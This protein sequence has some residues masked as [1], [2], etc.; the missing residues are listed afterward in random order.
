MI[1][2]Q[3]IIEQL[4]D[5]RVMALLDKLGIP[6]ED[7]PDCLIMPTVCHNQNMEEAS[8]KLYYYKNTHIFY[9][10]TEDGAMSIFNFLKHFYEVR[11][12]AYD[13]YTD[14]YELVLGCSY[15]GEQEYNPNAYKS[16]RDNY[17]LRKERKE[18]PSYPKEVMESF[19]KYYPIEWLNDGISKEAM[20]KFG[21][22]FSPSQNKIIIPHYDVGGRLVGIR[23]RALNEE[24]IENWG[25]YMPVQ[26]EGKWYSHPLSLN[27][28]GLNQTKE[29]IKATGIA[30]LFEAEK[31]V[32]QMESFNIPNCAVAVCGNKLNKYALDILVR[33]C[34][35]KEIVIC[36]DK[37]ELPHES[38]YFN[39]LYELC[40]KY[41]VYS[42]F[43]FIY[44][45]ENLLDLKDSPTDK[46]EEIFL[47]LLKK[48][49]KV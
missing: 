7:K 47:K 22:R 39:H 18:L 29:N 42:N 33:A 43:S 35:P 40:K 24:D 20:D 13:W 41:S 45:R 38:K 15:F 30:Y 48:R 6:Y 49:V 8:Q 10:Y 25:K 2:Y 5:N 16:I 1:D 23:G 17:T 26:I 28:Y 34:H 19:I 4:D 37:E 31:S 3:E 14:I 44:D 12:I 21:I 9:C 27:L 11:D 36:F 46:G 32:L